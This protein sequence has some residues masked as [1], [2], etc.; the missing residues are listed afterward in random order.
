MN[1]YPPIPLL[2]RQINRYPHFSILEKNIISMPPDIDYIILRNIAE[3]MTIM[4]IQHP[5]SFEK[6]IDLIEK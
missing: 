3:K 5:I 1:E 4:N 2:L 6:I